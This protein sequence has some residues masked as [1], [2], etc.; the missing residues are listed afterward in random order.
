M[1]ITEKAITVTGPKAVWTVFP[2]L[3]KGCGLCIEKCAIKTLVW[4]QNLGVYGT[5]TP[6]VTEEIPC[7]ACKMCETVCPDCAITVTKPAK[8]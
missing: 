3:C 7:T 1:S 6:Q 8:Q 5:P 2:A 4:S